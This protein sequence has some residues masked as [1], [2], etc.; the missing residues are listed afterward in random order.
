MGFAA[1]AVAASLASVAVAQLSRALS[2]K[3]VG[4]VY[5]TQ[6]APAEFAGSLSAGWRHRVDAK[7]LQIRPN[8][9]GRNCQTPKP[10]T[11]VISPTAT[12]S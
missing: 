11:T 8:G 5:W 10:V 9:A 7:T 2:V 6:G 12:P 4:D 3:D 1:F